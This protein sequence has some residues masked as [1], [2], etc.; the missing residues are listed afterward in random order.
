[1]ATKACRP[2]GRGRRRGDLLLGGTAC[3]R[4]TAT[5][6]IGSGSSSRSRRPTCA[7][8]A[9][10]DFRGITRGSSRSS[11]RSSPQDPQRHGD[12]RLLPRAYMTRDAAARDL[13]PG[14]PHPSHGV[15]AH[16]PR[17]SSATAPRARRF[18]QPR[19]RARRAC[20]QTESAFEHTNPEG[21]RAGIFHPGPASTCSPRSATRPIAG[22]R[23]ADAL[24]ARVMR[25]SAPAP[26]HSKGRRAP[27][28]LARD[29]R[30]RTTVAVSRPASSS[31]SRPMDHRRYA[32]RRLF[33]EASRATGR[34]SRRPGS[35]P[36]APLSRGQSSPLATRPHRAP[37]RRGR[38]AVEAPRGPPTRSGDRP[39]SRARRA[40]ARGLGDPRSPG[41][42]HDPDDALP[43]TLATLATLRLAAAS[44][45]RG[46]RRSC[47][48]GAL[49][50][51][52]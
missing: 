51:G 28:V 47:S 50:R 2:L 49:P 23:S 45:D 40:G 48:A 14:L 41:H 6:T 42:A 10:D 1:M 5:P 31:A 26:R 9:T 37:R 25:Q 18:W 27:D 20:G 39:R 15:C 36:R 17:S 43:S 16:P 30:P 12:P 35:P 19:R 29:R 21:R 33:R 13:V 38:G 44:H 32:R 4:P 24:R 46:S 11:S 7:P 22:R 34:E 8:A 3:P 52:T